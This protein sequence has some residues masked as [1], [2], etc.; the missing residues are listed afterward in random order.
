MQETNI[1]EETNLVI[2]KINSNIGDIDKR[3]KNYI[4]DIL[5]FVEKEVGLKNVLS[6]ILFG[7][8]RKAR[9][10]ENS[11]ISDC[12]LLIIFKDNIPLRWIKKIEN[13]FMAL[14]VKH[15]FREYQSHFF[16]K[17]LWVV[18]QTTGMF[19]SHFLTKRNFFLEAEFHR[20]FQV[21]KI[22][23]KLFAP[24]NIVLSSALD[25]SSILYGEDQ[26]DS[27]KSRVTV[28]PYDMFKSIFM[29]TII[30]LSSIVLIPFKN[31]D[32]MR[33]MLEAVKWSLRASNYY[34]FEDSKMLPKIINRFITFEKSKGYRRRA[35][36]Y[37]N[38]FMKL[39]KHPHRDIGFMLR[40]P[41]R[42]LKIHM[43]G[44]LYKPKE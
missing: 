13:Y 14:E 19:I 7:S 16:S 1:V 31:L 5:V 29:N 17:I 35:T 20:I 22:L 3:A 37:Y 15:E 38:R 33:F 34:T 9:K 6:I 4:N 21:N 32:S 42:I 40:C 8:Q 30:S 2:N 27:V 18:Q 12:D 10:Q 24:A 43:K 44:L 11:V 41:F 36:V 28:R 25:N 26:R 23:S 39:R